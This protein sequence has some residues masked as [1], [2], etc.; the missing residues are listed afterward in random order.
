MGNILSSSTIYAVAYLTDLGRNYLFDP[1]NSGRFT[2][3]TNTGNLVD[4]FKIAY[5]SMSDPDYNYKVTSGNAFE[6]GDIADVSGKNS[7]CIKGAI[8]E[9]EVGLISANGE[10]GGVPNVGSG[11]ANPNPSTNVPYTLATSNS[12][13]TISINL[14]AINIITE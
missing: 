10:I 14:N 3:N 1:L 11:T 6:S 9:E 7:D 8:M 12:E 2:V 4:S 5:F 13:N